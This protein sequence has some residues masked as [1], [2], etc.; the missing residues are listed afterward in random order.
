LNCEFVLTTCPYCGCGCSFYLQ[1]IDNRIEGVIPCQTHPI[2][3]GK[4]CIKGWNAHQFVGSEKR[5]KKPLIKENGTFKEVGW[6]E[7]IEY[8]AAQLKK[9]KGENGV[10]SLG[11]LSSAKC[12][13]E[14]NFLLMK[15]ARSVMGT[16]SIDHCARL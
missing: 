5:L 11:V 15:F 4:L 7:A 16:N 2:S 6:D 9:I 13:N 12:T 14:E 1:V 8:T 10:E 3:E